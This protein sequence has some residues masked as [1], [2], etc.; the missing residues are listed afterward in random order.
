MTNVAFSTAAT[1]VKAHQNGNDSGAVNGRGLRHRKMSRNQALELAA[2]IATGRPFVPSLHHLADIFGVPV[3]SLSKAV[4]ARAAAQEAEVASEEAD[5]YV[6]L[7]LE[8]DRLGRLDREKGWA[9]VHAWYLAS[10]EVRESFVR[11]VGVDA[12][13]DVIARLIR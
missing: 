10:S 13:W 6:E 7:P 8:L 1:A 2:D 5:R 4:K 12:V 9:L 11:E 3:G